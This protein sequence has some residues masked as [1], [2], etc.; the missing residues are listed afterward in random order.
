MMTP[1]LDAELDNGPADAIA[2]GPPNV[3]VL[4]PHEVRARQKKYLA[5]LDRDLAKERSSLEGKVRKVL[6]A[7]FKDEDAVTMMMR[8][9]API[10]AAGKEGGRRERGKMFQPMAAPK[11]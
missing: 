1:V 6:V 5:Q 9:I 11:K 2:A 8:S 4:K 7:H 10:L 3:V